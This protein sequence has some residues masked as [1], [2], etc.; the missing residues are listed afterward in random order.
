MTMNQTFL[1]NRQ[2]APQCFLSNHKIKITQTHYLDVNGEYQ[3][4]LVVKFHVAGQLVFL[5]C[6]QK[7][8]NVI[9]GN[10]NPLS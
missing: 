9:Q 5:R 6:T 10:V 2:K 1:S 7:C 3:L 4:K 8:F